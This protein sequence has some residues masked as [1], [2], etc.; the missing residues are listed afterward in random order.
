MIKEL[1][2]QF[3]DII[4]VNL[5]WILTSFLGLLITLGAATTAMFR[6]TQ[7]ILKKNE[8]TNVLH[9]YIQSFKENFWI[10]T[11]VWVVLLVLAAPLFY[12]YHYALNQEIFILLV[13][14]IIGAY[15]LLIVTIY[16]FP[17]IA[18]FKTKNYYQLMKN[19][20]IIAN[21]NLWTNFKVLGSLAF[22]ILLIFVVHES[23]ILIG[24]GLYGVL[25]SF[26][27]KKVFKPYL[28][29][30]GDNNEEEGNENAIFKF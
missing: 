28:L 11:L 14:A 6:V 21:T 18:T 8:P 17:I 26:H 5:L 22:L 27:L 15:Q 30:L 1:F 23:L 7:Q 3:T 16:I 9:L 10:S 13:I 4:F 25:V 19:T 24:V 12:M 20:L 29:E 2:R